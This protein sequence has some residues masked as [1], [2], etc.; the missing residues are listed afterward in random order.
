MTLRSRFALVFV[1]FATLITAGMGWSAWQL[2]S[3]ALEAE[4]DE[5]LLAVAGVAAQQG[6]RAEDVLFFEEGD[7]R[8]EE[9]MAYQIRLR[10]LRSEYVDL[11]EIF[12]WTPQAPWPTALVTA[13]VADSVRVGQRLFWLELY[14]SELETAAETGSA[15][16]RLFEGNDGRYYKYGFVRLDD[17]EAF[18]AVQIRADYQA[19][20]G[21]LLRRIVLGSFGAALLAGLLGWGLAANI[22]SPLERL[23]RA[24]LRIQRGRM[25]TPIEAGREDEL[26][27]LGRAMER[28]RAGILQ[29]DENLRLMLS[30][31]AHEIRNPLGGLE[32]FA[33]AAQETEDADERFRILQRVRE[34]VVGLNGIIDEFLTYARP[35][36]TETNIHDLKTPLLEAIS[37]V[38]AELEQS[39]GVLHLDLPEGPLLALADPFQVKRLAL[40]L[41]RNAS[42]AGQTV[43]I[44]GT[45]EHGEV[46]LSVRDDG[47]GV[48]EDLRDRLFEPFV[49]DKERGAGLGLA[50]VKGIVESNSARVLLLD[51]EQSVGSG[52]EFQVYFRGPEDLPLSEELPED[53]HSST[54]L[55][56]RA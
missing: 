16:T 12:R 27:R 4:L 25:E 43:W 48:R 54:T 55:P 10:L 1:T 26:G 30:Q 11:A 7:E 18:L 51:P 2:A 33:S 38:Q 17:S 19:P 28:M 52:A 56:A 32:L 3:Q 9:W 53:D 50:I 29:R 5:K 49:T 21:R 37:L 15:T 42:Q 40:N 45:V 14:R 22:V 23:S 8:T 31:V 36:K 47:P 39:G 13:A 34:E 6:I 46:L 24:A 20:L 41:L 44:K 35:H